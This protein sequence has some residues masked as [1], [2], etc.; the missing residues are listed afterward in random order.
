[1]CLAVERGKKLKFD[2]EG[3]R[4]GYK[5]VYRVRETTW[6]NTYYR[7]QTVYRYSL[8]NSDRPFTALTIDE[9][10]SNRVDLGIHVF[11]DLEEAKKF[12][13]DSDVVI[14]EVECD[15]DDFV[16]AGQFVTESSEYQSSVWKSV[17]VKGEVDVS[18][19]N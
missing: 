16:A 14:L 13:G 8:I 19:A 12:C 10:Y 9:I 15:R 5:V 6:Y 7:H 4:V 1:M 3:K 17:L 11:D 18:D 2:A